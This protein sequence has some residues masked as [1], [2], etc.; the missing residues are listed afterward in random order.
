M[1]GQNWEKS[2]GGVI[3]EE[4]FAVQQTSDSGFIVVGSTNSFGAGSTDI[5]L[6]KTNSMGD[7]MWTR[8]YG[9]IYFDKGLSVR[10]TNDGGFIIGC[11]FTINPSYGGDLE[12][13]K[14][15]SAGIIVWTKVM[16]T[17]QWENCGAVIQT[18]DSGFCVTGNTGN[19]GSGN[20]DLFLSKTDM[21]GD[22]VWAKRFGGPNIELGYSLQQTTDSGFIVSG[23]S[24]NAVDGFYYAYLI[25][26]K[27]NGD[28]LWTRT[29]KGSGHTYAQSVLQTSDGGFITA[30]ISGENYWA[31][32]MDSAGIIEWSKEINK[33]VMDRCFS[34]I[35]TDDNGYI[36]AGLTDI[37]VNSNMLLVKLDSLGSEVWS[38]KYS[39]NKWMGNVMIQPVI[40]NGFIIAGTIENSI[41][42]NVDLH[43]VKSMCENF[44]VSNI[45][46]Q[47]TFC[48]GD[49]LSATLSTG[50]QPG[51][52]Y[53]WTLNGFNIVGSN[54]ANNIAVTDGNYGLTV[55]DSLGCNNQSNEIYIYLPK[56]YFLPSPNEACAGDSIVMGNWNSG[57]D[58]YALYHW[59]FGDGDSVNGNTV[60][61]AYQTTGTYWITRSVVASNGSCNSYVDS[62][63]ISATAKPPVDF[64][65]LVNSA[66]MLNAT[67]CPGDKFEFIPYGFSYFFVQTPAFD[68]TSYLWDFGDG[69]TD[70]VKIPVH[71][72]SQLGNFV[73]K[74]TVTNHCGNSDTV[75]MPVVIDSTLHAI[76]NF[77]WVDSARVFGDIINACEPISFLTAYGTSYH[78]NFADGT[79]F[80]TGIDS[81]AHVYNNP[82]NYNIELITTNGCGSSDTISK[83]ITVV[84]TC[85]GIDDRTLN[86]VNSVVVFPNPF[87]KTATVSIHSS[88]QNQDFKKIEM[89]VFNLQGKKIKIFEANQ[90]EFN[91]D[92]EG[93]AHGMYFFTII[94][95]N[96]NII[97]GKFIAQ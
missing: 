23:A 74:L 84:G 33:V 83:S 6:V 42:G 69:T 59:D 5:Y 1:H 29:F 76:A 2:Y 94:S 89:I 78:W 46:I 30:G 54:S 85:T 56:A 58:Y 39:N 90:A 86:E 62:V 75:S 7:T 48:M 92:T 34:I 41:T 16:G 45:L 57:P 60:K 61:H 15:D 24:Y 40:G 31:L 96:E 68:A 11:E 93:L 73:V 8:V 28:T 67:G 19:I 97:T 87:V 70:T 36:L 81:V 9:G 17:N 3:K 63:V 12:L 55:T 64:V 72:Y 22:T 71:Y 82:G 35:Q 25:K 65:I 79:S 44:P 43:L 80:T 88:K 37:Q 38:K 13:I 52:S 49:T 14:T 50:F 18:F 27:S 20:V 21:N 10:Q 47:D 66:N 77:D 51:L 4:G 32:K 26:T 91:I 53:Q 95:S